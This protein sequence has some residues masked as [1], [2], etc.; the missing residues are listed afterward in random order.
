VRSDGDA[1][2]TIN[3]TMVPNPIE[4]H[5]IDEWGHVLE[6][7]GVHWTAGQDATASGQFPTCQ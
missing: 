5:V 7:D 1:H 2:F 3:G 4:L 6:D